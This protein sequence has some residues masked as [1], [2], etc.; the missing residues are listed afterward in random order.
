MNKLWLQWLSYAGLV[1]ISL[2][3]QLLRPEMFALFCTPLPVVNIGTQNGRLELPLA[4]PVIPIE[5]IK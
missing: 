5:R 3:L 2:G 1:V 4:S